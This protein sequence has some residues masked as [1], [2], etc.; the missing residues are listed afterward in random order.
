MGVQFFILLDGI[1]SVFWKLALLSSLDVLKP[2]ISVWLE[3]EINFFSFKPRRNYILSL[4]TQWDI[5]FPA[6]KNFDIL[7]MK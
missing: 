2:I 4:R 6:K 7:D 3:A 5:S 1:W